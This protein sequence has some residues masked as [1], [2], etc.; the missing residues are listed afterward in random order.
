MARGAKTSKR[1]RC[2]EGRSVLLI[3]GAGAGLCAASAG[4][5]YVL[6][7]SQAL[8]RTSRVITALPPAGAV[9]T[10]ALPN[11]SRTGSAAFLVGSLAACAI[12]TQAAV[13]ATR[14]PAVA[15]SAKASCTHLDREAPNLCGDCPRDNMMPSPAAKITEKV[16]AS[17]AFISSVKPSCIHPDR[18]A[19][20]LCGDCPR[21]NMMPSPPAVESKQ[22]G[23]GCPAATKKV[24][25]SA[26]FVSSAKPACTHPDR[27]APNL[28]GDCPRN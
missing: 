19:P 20:N 9:G 15:L 4:L 12:V 28:C 11:Q 10:G 24:C 1:A 25:A 22:T 7:G 5:S 27:D 26:A 3:A 16:C 2:A 21:D 17:A 14:R 8:A 23:S 18:D 6:P 13:R